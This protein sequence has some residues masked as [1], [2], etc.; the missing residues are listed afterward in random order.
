MTARRPERRDQGFTLIELMVSMGIMSIIL[1]VVI[2]AITQIYSATTR[3]DT[4][5]YDRDQ[6]TVA[7][8]RLDKEI[9]YAQ[10]LA[11]PGQVGTRY[12]LEYAVPNSG[13]RQLAYDSGVLT[14]Y[15]WTLPSTSPANPQVLASSLTLV[16]GTAPFT[17]YAANSTPY[18]SATAGTA[19]V[20]RNYSPDHALLRIQV[21]VVSGRTTVPFDTLYT[22]ENTSRNTPQINACSAGRPTS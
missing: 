13:C 5:T 20:G 17:V 11:V 6:L 2:G 10:W 3:V 22:A 12:Y 14:L 21:N 16:S 15:S 7:F 19:G 18:A 9:R 8:R 4:T 1:A